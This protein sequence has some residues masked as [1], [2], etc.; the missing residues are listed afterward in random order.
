MQNTAPKIMVDLRPILSVNLP[1][2]GLAISALKENAGMIHP[3]YSW[4]FRSLSI[5]ESSG[6]TKLNERKNNKAAAHSL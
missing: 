2:K 5:D 4:A 3:K 1:L 6:I